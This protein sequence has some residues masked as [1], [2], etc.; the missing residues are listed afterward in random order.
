[1]C[2]PPTPGYGPRQWGVGGG[3]EHL[4]LAVDLLRDCKMGVGLVVQGEG[5]ISAGEPF[6]GTISLVRLVLKPPPNFGAQSD[7]FLAPW[8]GGYIFCG[9]VL[10]PVCCMSG[11]VFM[12]VRIPKNVFLCILRIPKTEFVCPPCIPNDFFVYPLRIP[13]TVVPATVHKAP[14]FW[15]CRKFPPP[16]T[17]PP[18]PLYGT[19]TLKAECKACQQVRQGSGRHTTRRSKRWVQAT[20]WSHDP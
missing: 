13:R 3:G 17:P 16:T 7:P 11:S 8:V 9:E 6:R 5:D 1:M 10:V 2:Q 12:R 15:G 18:P 14:K 20:G 19:P 4:I